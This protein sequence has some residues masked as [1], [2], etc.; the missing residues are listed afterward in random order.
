MEV[1]WVWAR[2]QVPTRRPEAFAPLN[3]DLDVSH[4]SAG[5]Q[6][7]SP[8]RAMNGSNCWAKH[9]S[10]PSSF[11]NITYFSIYLESGVRCVALEVL[12]FAL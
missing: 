9:L 12:E 8:L 7:R 1:R 2:A 4:P 5:N 10:T 6:T 3:L 11:L